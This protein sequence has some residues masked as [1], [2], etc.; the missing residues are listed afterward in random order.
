M[1]GPEAV[2]GL[3]LN[4]GTVAVLGYFIW[5]FVT[6]KILPA[7]VVDKQLDTIVELSK[8]TLTDGFKDAVQEAVRAGF[9]DA[10]HEHDPERNK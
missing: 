4:G 1:V 3:I 7:S 10:L 9:L 6:G 5:A 2:V 8:L